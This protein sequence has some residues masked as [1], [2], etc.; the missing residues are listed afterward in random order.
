MVPVSFN[1]V[2]HV[3]RSF[4]AAFTS[5]LGKIYLLNFV[6]KKLTK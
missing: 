3:L 5:R 1:T 6:E 4:F 2:K